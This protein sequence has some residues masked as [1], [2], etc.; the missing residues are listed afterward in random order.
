MGLH[1]RRAALAAAFAVPM[2]LA[3][4]SVAMA[5]GN[6]DGNGNRDSEPPVVDVKDNNINYNANNNTARASNT[7][8]NTVVVHEDNLIRD[9]LELVG[10]G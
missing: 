6:E 7:N 4:P 8:Y 9:V 3:G 10:L 1:I 5:S 2:L